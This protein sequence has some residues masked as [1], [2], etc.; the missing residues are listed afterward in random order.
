MKERKPRWL[1]AETRIHQPRLTNTEV[2][3]WWTASDNHSLTLWGSETLNIEITIKYYFTRSFYSA[4]LLSIFHWL[5]NLK[6]QGKYLKNIRDISKTFTTG[7]Q[8]KSLREAEKSPNLWIR[9][10][11]N[12]QREPQQQLYHAGFDI[13]DKY[14]L[15]CFHDA[16]F[17]REEL[18]S[19]QNKT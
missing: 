6:E 17:L 19:K 5:E 13:I 15:Y 4:W 1:H 9:E 2:V 14:F 11:L 8:L 18:A 7:D 3:L 12:G 10:N 16:G